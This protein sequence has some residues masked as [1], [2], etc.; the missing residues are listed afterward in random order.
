MRL[1][2]SSPSV[3]A[4]YTRICAHV[5]CTHMLSA[6]HLLQSSVFRHIT[7]GIPLEVNRQPLVQCDS[8]ERYPLCS[9]TN[10]PSSDYWTTLNY[11][12]Y[13]DG[14]HFVWRNLRVSQPQW[15]E[16]WSSGLG[17]CNFIGDYH[18]FG[19]TYCLHFQNIIQKT[20]ILIAFPLTTVL[21]FRSQDSSVV[22][23]TS[24][25]LD[26]RG[27]IPGRGK[28]FFCSPQHPECL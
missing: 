8:G 2:F 28:R 21:R 6:S 24:Y 5:Q 4:R 26:S 9:G 14:S 12:Q 22:T 3:S 1:T 23:A 11:L 17:R 7:P 18:C 10:R 16:L 15:L 25:G 13:A 20:T 27:S 19:G